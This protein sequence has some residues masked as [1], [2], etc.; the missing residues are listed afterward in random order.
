MGGGGGEQINAESRDLM[1][2]LLVDVHVVYT[3]EW[4]GLRGLSVCIGKT[5]HSRIVTGFG[6]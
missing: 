4:V 3:N 5:T 1:C 2:R 6:L